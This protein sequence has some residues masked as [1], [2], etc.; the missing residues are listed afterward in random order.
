MKNGVPSCSNMTVVLDGL[1]LVR[2]LVHRLD[3]LDLN[4]ADPIVELMTESPRYNPN[5]IKGD[6]VIGP[7]SHRVA[8]IGP[9]DMCPS[10]ETDQSGR[11]CFAQ[12]DETRREGVEL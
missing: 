2:S 10:A 3:L 12:F 11:T 7:Y 5:T 8:A 1:L 4:T 6:P 9:V